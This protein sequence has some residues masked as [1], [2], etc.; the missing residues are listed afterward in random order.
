MSIIFL[1]HSLEGLIFKEMRLFEIVYSASTNYVS[2][3]YDK[4]ERQQ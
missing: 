4:H 2:K 1:V 3:G